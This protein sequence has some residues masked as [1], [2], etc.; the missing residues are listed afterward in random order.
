MGLTQIQQLQIF[1]TLTVLDTYN[2]MI[3]HDRDKQSDR[4]RCRD[5]QVPG[6]DDLPDPPASHIRY[7]LVPTTP[8]REGGVSPSSSPSNFFGDRF[9]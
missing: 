4:L 6:V 1:L 2:I 8:G 7:L 3:S 9:R 5:A